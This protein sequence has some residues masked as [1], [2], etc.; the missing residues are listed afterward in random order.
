MGAPGG[1]SWSAPGSSSPG[2]TGARIG[3]FPLSPRTAVI[4]FVAAY[5]LLG[6]RGLVAAAM[7]AGFSMIQTDHDCPGGGGSSGGGSSG[8]GGGKKIG[9][10]IADMPK[11]PPRGG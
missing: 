9:K 4:C 11:S 6:F 5:L 2:I 8:T 7:L 1:G 3:E 10:T